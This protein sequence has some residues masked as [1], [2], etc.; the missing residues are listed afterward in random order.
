MSTAGE[1][2]AR[3]TAVRF[4]EQ[5]LPDL[6]PPRILDDPFDPLAGSYH[7]T[8]DPL[9]YFML[10]LAHFTSV[11]DE[12]SPHLI[13][14]ELGH[15]F[16][17][18]CGGRRDV[19][20]EFLAAMGG[21][22]A[23]N[24]HKLRGEIFAEHFVRAYDPSYHGQDYAGLVGMVPFDATLM[25]AFVE[26]MMASTIP[27]MPP[28]IS[29]IDATW[30]GPLPPSNYRR[31]RRVPI[32]TVVFHHM[33][34]FFAGTDAHFKIAGIELSAH[35]GVPHAP[36]LAQWVSEADTAFHAGGDA[37]NPARDRLINDRSLGV[38]V[39]DSAADVFTDS[40]YDRCAAIARMAH[41]VY[42]V[43]YDRMWMVGH[44]D[45]DGVL[46]ACPG[47]LDIDRIVRQAAAGEEE[48]MFTDEDRKMLK[49]CYDH[50]EA[51]EPMVWTARLQKWL[52]KA[53]RSLWPNVDVSGPD[54]ESGQP[55]K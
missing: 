18:W 15:L 3:R 6:Y 30:M 54:V 37:Q 25:R 27:H 13:I 38:E 39:E 29:N 50:L 51:Y 45:V 26:A 32:D 34:G 53:F 36:F 12:H 35:Y 2:G 55:F 52:A 46:T 10:L 8:N 7:M 48:D 9:G 41:D 28:P 23:L 19:I 11:P 16:A 24:E 31:G 21:D 4:L 49:R 20:R 14:H 22:P 43:P 47:A 42:G 44:R 1:D 40:Q 33:A 17:Y 5:H